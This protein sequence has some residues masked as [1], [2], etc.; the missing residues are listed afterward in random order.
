M[1]KNFLSE[2]INYYRDKIKQFGSTAEGMD[3]KNIDTQYLRFDIISR[4]IDFS[5]HPSVLDVGC[6]N[7]EFLNYT[8]D[9]SRSIQYT[10]LDAVSEMVQ[11]T[12]ERFG[13]DSAIEA[14]LL[15]WNTDKKF[16][17]VIASG[18]FNAK[19]SSTD[20]EW[21]SYFYGNLKKMYDLANVAII[22]NCMTS[23]V[24]YKYDRL[25]YPTPDEL[26]DFA[27]KNLSRNFILDHS[28][29][30]YEVTMVVFK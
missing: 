30:L 14:D 16:D 10:G 23:H 17:Y 15:S 19:L 4:Y 21:K 25:Y 22:F 20:E 29:P 7:G 3:W 1:D 5:S 12:N 2:S 9:H 18:T 28:Y 26:T 6:G 24:D 13:N 8:K 11:L 27:V